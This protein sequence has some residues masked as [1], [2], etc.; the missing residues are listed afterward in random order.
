MLAVGRLRRRR[1]TFSMIAVF[2]TVVASTWIVFSLY[3]NSYR[4]GG[5]PRVGL[6]DEQRDDDGRRGEVVGDE[7][8]SSSTMHNKRR[9]SNSDERPHHDNVVASLLD[10]AAPSVETKRYLPPLEP[11]VIPEVD[12]HGDTW[13]YARRGGARVR[14]TPAPFVNRRK[15][16]PAVAAA[17]AGRAI[18]APAVGDHQHDDDGGPNGCA[19]LTSSR[20]VSSWR[21][22]R[23]DLHC[24]AADEQGAGSGGR[25][26]EDR[27][28]WV[29]EYV[30]S[31]YQFNPQI[32]VHHN[33]LINRSIVGPIVNGDTLGSLAPP[34]EKRSKERQ[35]EEGPRKESTR[36]SFVHLRNVSCHA[37]RM[38]LR[39]E[40]DGEFFTPR[41][42]SNVVGISL[43]AEPP[44]SYK[45]RTVVDR[46]IVRQ[47]RFDVEN[48]YESFHAYLN[49]FGVLATLRLDPT[50]VQFVFTDGMGPRVND[51]MFWRSFNLGRFPVVYDRS[52]QVVGVERLHSDPQSDVVNE[53]TP[54]PDEPIT[55]WRVKTLVQPPSTGQSMLTSERGA[56]GGKFR[57]HSCR[58]SW[59]RLAIQWMRR[60]LQL[61][62]GLPPR[63]KIASW[64]RRRGRRDDD[65]DGGGGRN[66]NNASVGGLSLSAAVFN[67]SDD[68]DVVVVPRRGHSL[69]RRHVKIIWSSRT[70]HYR[71]EHSDAQTVSTRIMLNED[72]FVAALG[73]ALRDAMWMNTT[74]TALS[75]ELRRVNF[76]DLN[77]T[78]SITALEWGDVFVSAHGAALTWVAFLP[79]GSGVV[80]I[81]GGNRGDSNR[82]FHN[83][84]SLT[85]LHYRSFVSPGDAFNLTW[86]NRSVAKIAE[87]IRDVTNAMCLL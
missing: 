51:H 48:I 23:K 14:L 36:A 3:A 76:G 58:S 19:A 75:Y 25:V 11:G 72:G 87:L 9:P 59:L 22:S 78:E 53:R 47:R 69:H 83:L 66:V 61:T 35:N 5:S 42:I 34:V 73:K 55:L 68:G 86:T 40:N 74:T 57:P 56:L 2:M 1:R 31:S 41:W 27:N 82:H 30:L 71:Y 60:G 17:A 24:H 28:H 54:L 4:R 50:T 13:A 44:T 8:S 10:A 32:R 18:I 21:A 65:D 26:A 33:V 64:R 29:Q 77:V 43:T 6:V 62:Y 45:L 70:V 49:I 85:D 37:S 81:F 52:N 20:L 12:D 63:P 46:V 80:E 15:S 84:A 38:Q 79:S 67:G 7:R 16:A 39:G